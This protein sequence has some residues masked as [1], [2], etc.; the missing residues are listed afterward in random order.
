MDIESNYNFE[1]SVDGADL[2]DETQI[3][4]VFREESG[5]VLAYLI[6][7][8]RDFDLAEDMLQE[9]FILA[10]EKWPKIGVPR[11]PGAWITT[12][13]RNRSID[14]LRR[15]K[16][17]AEK[18]GEV[19]SM[20]KT[21][22]ASAEDE[23]MDEIPDERLKL[24]FTCCHPVLAL[25]AQVALTLRTL[26]GLTTEAIASAFLQPKATIAQRIVR[27]KRKIKQ[28]AVPY[29]VP[30]LHALPERID[31]VLA[32]IYLIFNEGYVTSQGDNLTK[33]ELSTEALRLG[34]VLCML[35][36]DEPETLGLMALMLIQDSRRDAR[37]GS[38]G[39]LILL[40]DQNR[41]LWDADKI[42]E[43]VMLLDHAI[44]LGRPG[45]YQV[46]AAIAALHAEADSAET[47]DW[48]QIAL[49]YKSLARYNQSPVIELNRAVAVSMVEGPVSALAI[50]DQPAVSDDLQSYHLFHSTR[51]EF[52]QQAG[53]GADAAEAYAVAIELVNNPVERQ[54]LERKLRMLKDG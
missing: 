43:G 31:A 29:E 19:Q 30:P 22:S 45:G 40:P 5:R 42:R 37:T 44:T 53:F 28:A 13:A 41:A 27:A 23:L 8:L 14:R 9:A 47:T 16:N 26:G 2:A 20:Q 35:M 38:Q 18:L 52:L 24:M 49:L 1:Q 34:R 15:K 6:G 25:D 7:Y 4:R 21:V 54:F 50:V 33:A 11:N 3:S 32:V 10:L 12:T 48:S 39:Q 46:Q 51:A 17:Y 36:P